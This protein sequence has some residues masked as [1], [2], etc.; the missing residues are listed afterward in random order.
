MNSDRLIPLFGKADK[1]R[2][3]ALVGWQIANV[4]RLPEPHKFEVT[5]IASILN[6]LTRQIMLG[7]VA[8]L[9]VTEQQLL[10]LLI[11][12]N[13]VERVNRETNIFFNHPQPMPRLR[14]IAG[15]IKWYPQD[16][17]A[18]VIVHQMGD[19]TEQPAGSRP[20]TLAAYQFDPPIPGIT[21]VF[22]NMQ[23]I[24]GMSPNPVKKRTTIQLA[25]DAKIDI[26]TLDHCGQDVSCK[27][28]VT[29]EQ[30]NTMA[31]TNSKKDAR[32]LATYPQNFC[33]ECR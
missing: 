23:D 27:Y 25:K 8:F 29:C 17:I 30:H 31:G 7:R 15:K 13:I 19:M 26:E 9:E 3:V 2:Q 32:I 11:A 5:V 33:D 14:P 24:S 4:S 12:D 6:N 16:N 1:N 28:I 20:G 18:V 22:A 10:D 21:R